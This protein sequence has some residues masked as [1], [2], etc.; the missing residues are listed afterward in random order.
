QDAYIFSGIDI[1]I[2][3]AISGSKIAVQFALGMDKEYPF[4]A[5]LS[6]SIIVI[7]GSITYIVIECLL[8]EFIHIFPASV[9]LY[10]QVL[11][12]IAILLG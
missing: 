9:S 10:N 4:A 3:S 7:G 1:L 5:L 8:L 12:I 2:Q 6:A 11:L